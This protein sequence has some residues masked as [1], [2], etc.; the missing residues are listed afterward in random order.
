MSDM[1]TALG[2]FVRLSKVLVGE[3]NLPDDLVA[4]AIGAHP[5]Y[6]ASQPDRIPGPEQPAKEADR[7]NARDVYC[8][9]AA[10]PHAKPGVV[11]CCR[12]AATIGAPAYG[13]HP[14]GDSGT[15]DSA[16]ITN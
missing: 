7:K 11:A 9:L 16:A 12:V 2:S 13:L 10:S 8:D 15:K 5:P 14:P 4:A 3:E 6:I 1:G